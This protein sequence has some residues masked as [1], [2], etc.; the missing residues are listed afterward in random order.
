MDNASHALLIAGGILLGILTLSLFVAMFAN[1]STM[2]NAREAKKDIQRL[3][4]W[5][6]TWEVYDKQYLYGSDVLTVINKALES[7]DYPVEIRLNNTTVVRDYKLFNSS[8]RDSLKNSM[9]TRIYTCTEML[10]NEEG[11]INL[12]S[13]EF[14]E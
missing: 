13:F 14:V 3:A 7:N 6:R 12:I 9:K 10:R 4:E 5:N 1:L 11:R 2:Q 8:I